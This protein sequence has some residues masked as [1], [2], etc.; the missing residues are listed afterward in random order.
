VL[1]S[2]S[3]LRQSK[4][5]LPDLSP[6]CRNEDDFDALLTV[7]AMVRTVAE[8]RPMSCSLVDPI[9]EGGILATGDID[10]PK[11]PYRRPTA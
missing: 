11:A 9:A 2:A 5:A 4:T 10:L 1:E 6:A 8:G 7:A 3:W